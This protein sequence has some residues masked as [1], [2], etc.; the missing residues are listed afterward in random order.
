[1]LWIWPDKS[2]N[3]FAESEKVLLPMDDD[4]ADFLERS[5]TEGTFPMYVRYL[6]YS[7]D[8]LMENICDPSHVAVSHHGLMSPLSRYKAEPLQARLIRGTE[9]GQS[10]LAL[11]YKSPFPFIDYAQF[12]LRKP[13]VIIST[14]KKKDEDM[15]FDKSY[16]VATPICAGKSAIFVAVVTPSQTAQTER[17]NPLQQLFNRIMVLVLHATFYNPLFDGDSVFLHQQDKKIRKYGATFSAQE[18][19]YVPTPADLLVMDFRRWFENEGG[20]GEAYG[21]N[22]QLAIGSELTREEMLDRYEQHTKHCKV[23]REFLKSME[24][25]IKVLKL[26]SL[27]ALFIGSILLIRASNAPGFE[28]KTVIK[29]VSLRIAVVVGTLSSLLR[30]F[31]EKNIKPRFYFEDWVHADKD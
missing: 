4:G 1:M 12:E 15:L 10:T 21:G 6:P 7:F 5:A 20:H 2:T 25:F 24:S 8:V 30:A 16:L 18:R 19:Y 23:C 14:N 17:S 31:L 11:K 29:N 9:R 3:A 22:E 27:G 13:G 26:L 28:W